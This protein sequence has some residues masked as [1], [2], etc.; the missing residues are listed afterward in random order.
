MTNFDLTELSE[1]AKNA[2]SKAKDH[3]I[4]NLNSL[5]VLSEEGKDIK[6]NLDKESNEL[7]KNELI[8]NSTYAVLTEESGAH[9]NPKGDESSNIKWIVD[10]IDGTFNFKREIPH[11]CISVALW[12][13][14]EP[15]LG[16][17]LDLNSPNLF[18]ASKDG[19]FL[20]DQEINTSS[21]NDMKQA[22]ICT[23]FPIATSFDDKT[24]LNIAMEFKK[25]KKIR[26]LGSA[27][28]SLSYVACGKV[29][30][31]KEDNIRLWDVAAGIALV[32]FSGGKVS[33]KFDP[34]DSTLMNVIATN[35]KMGIL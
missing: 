12:D 21:V 20:N 7:I 3:I 2:A 26:M 25:Y 22:A 34:S 1:V 14:N 5:N 11:S 9:I 24:L 19:S 6:I 15:L 17:I 35:G 31:Y 13:S 10:P 33:Y 28:T 32:K 29:D 4:S 27:A 23:G 30:I 16:V 18:C 8:K